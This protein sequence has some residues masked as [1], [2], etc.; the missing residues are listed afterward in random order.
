MSRPLHHRLEGFTKEPGVLYPFGSGVGDVI[1]LMEYG[2]EARERFD[3]LAY[4]RLEVERNWVWCRRWRSIVR[5][6]RQ[7]MALT[8]MPHDGLSKLRAPV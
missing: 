7:A 5:V 8:Q 1:E 4:E 2:H 3:M 6:C